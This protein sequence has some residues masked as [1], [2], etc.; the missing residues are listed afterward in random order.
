M[1]ADLS[2][3]LY[4]RNYEIKNNNYSMKATNIFIERLSLFRVSSYDNNKKAIKLDR[5]NEAH[6]S[7]VRDEWIT[8]IASTHTTSFAL[9]DM[10]KVL[11]E[12]EYKILTDEEIHDIVIIQTNK[13]IARFISI[14]V[15]K[16]PEILYGLKTFM[17]N[18]E[19]I[20][21]LDAMKDYFRNISGKEWNEEL[22]MMRIEYPEI[23][24][25]KEEILNGGLTVI[26][27][28]IIASQEKEKAINNILKTKDIMISKLTM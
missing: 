25:D 19:T 15:E 27:D 4:M 6:S 22:N 12:I 17:N 9:F 10:D 24:N 16:N 8:S 3:I 21:T 5:K 20:K 11:K 23:Y 1:Y 18:G 2:A 14:L 26:T 7:L 13:G 28:K